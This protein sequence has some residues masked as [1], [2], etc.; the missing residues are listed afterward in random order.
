VN[1][2]DSFLVLLTCV[3]VPVSAACVDPGKRIDDFEGRVVDAEVTETIDAKPLDMI[4]DIS[5]SWYVTYSPVP[6]AP[7]AI[8]HFIWEVTLTPNGDGTAKVTVHSTPLNAIARTKIPP[9]TVGT[10]LPVSSAGEFTTIV[11]DMVLP[12]PSNPLS[13]SQV[14]LDLHSN[15]VIKSADFFCGAVSPGTVV[16]PPIDL[17]GSTFGGQRIVPGT[18]GAGLPAAIFACPVDV[19]DAGPI[20]AAAAPDAPEPD[21]TPSLPDAGLDAGI[22]AA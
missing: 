4:P 20:D 10:D 5:G 14:L 3:L 6:V 1:R 17:S 15:A 16:N 21:A 22:D 8:I 9:E 13:G 12:G 18:E 2:F 19:P 11:D 7:D